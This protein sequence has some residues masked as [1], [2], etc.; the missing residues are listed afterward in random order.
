[1]FHKC[2]GCQFKGEHDEMM[3]KPLGICKRGADLIEANRFYNAEKC[4][5]N[6]TKSMC[7]LNADCQNDCDICQ[8]ADDLR[9]TQ[10]FNEAIENIKTTLLEAIEPLC[11]SIIEAIHILCANIPQLWSKVKPYALLI[12]SYPNKKVIHLA[13]HHPKEKVRKKNM[14]RIRKWLEKEGK[15]DN[16]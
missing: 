8:L 15:Y 3:F 1:M 14:T 7:Y 4:P 5:F 13:L 6:E 11:D 2:D 9:K 16:I 10:D 12:H